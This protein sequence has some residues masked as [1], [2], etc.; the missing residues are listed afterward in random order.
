MVVLFSQ[1]W[2]CLVLSFTSHNSAASP[3]G[4]TQPCDLFG[5]IKSSVSAKVKQLKQT[6]YGTYRPNIADQDFSAHSVLQA[7]HKE[8]QQ[9]SRTTST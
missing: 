1:T 2:Y 3:T 8:L 4:T 7:W 9:Q 6:S 5:P